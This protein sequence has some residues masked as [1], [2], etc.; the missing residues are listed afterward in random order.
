MGCGGDVLKA[1]VSVSERYLRAYVGK[2]GGV[3][4]LDFILEEEGLFL[5]F[6]CR[7]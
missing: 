6:V 3:M 1:V 4:S 5:L 2:V 7:G